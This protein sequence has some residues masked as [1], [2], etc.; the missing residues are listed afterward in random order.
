MAGDRL[1]AI[2]AGEERRPAPMARAR[3]VASC[4]IGMAAVALGGGLA[5]CG[6]SAQKSSGGSSSP[7]PP[8][9]A[10]VGN[11]AIPNATLAHWMRA[12]APGHVLPNP[13]DYSACVAHEKA[14]ESQPRTQALEACAHEFQEVRQQA[15]GFLISSQWLIG[16]AGAEGVPVTRQD[17]ER[18]L[19]EKKRS[20]PNSEAEFGESLKAIDHTLADAELEIEAELAAEA[21]KRKL[22]AG[23][24]KLSDGQI[25]AY[26]ARH[27]Q[28]YHIPEIR[29]FG[30]FENLD[31]AAQARQLMRDVAAGKSGDRT[32]LHEK[33][34]R[35]P[36]GY[37]N[38]EKR[39]I[40]EAIFK[41]PLHVL[42]GPIRLNNLYFVIEITRIAHPY[43]QS[44]AQ[45]RTAIAKRLTEARE[46]R[47]LA[48]FVAAWRRR[49]LARTSCQPGFVVQKCRQYSGPEAAEDP[50]QL[51]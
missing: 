17:V 19:A 12:M 46:R 16:E 41:A 28:G 34:P 45:E 36:F 42:T 15:L 37:Y 3:L 18:R 7:P 5:A 48:A 44:L 33:L 29:Y 4:V 22:I 25:A 30:I 49:W 43:V 38:G 27:I 1:S 51:N 10:H 2:S 6:E 9:V 20:F 40:V 24:P 23:E 14:H 11:A 50:L 31:S 35:R 13:P 47:T 32:P 21:I 8:I 26:Y 39:T